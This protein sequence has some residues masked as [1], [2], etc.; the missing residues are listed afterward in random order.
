MEILGKYLSG[1]YNPSMKSREAL[2]ALAEITAYQWGM[3]TA[4]QAS[5]HGITRLDLSRLAADGQLERVAHGVYKDAGAPGGPHDALKAAWLSTD[6]K[7]MGEARLKDG[8]SGVVVA[9][10][11]AAELHAIGDFRALRHE[12]VCPGRRQ[13]QR[14]AIRYRQRTLDPSDVTLADGLPV[15]TMERTI[16]DLVDEV[17]DLSL[18]ADALRD[19]SRKRD[20]DLERLGSLL[21]PHAR[22]NGFKKGDGAALLDRLMEIAG[23]DPEAV[24]RR[25]AADASLGSRVAAT[26]LTRLSQEHIARLVM[27][28]EMQ[29]TIRSTQESV[30]ATVQSAMAPKLAAIDATVAGVSANV[31]KNSGLDEIARR[32]SAQVVNSNVMEEFSRAWV[33]ALSETIAVEPEPIT[34]NCETQNAVTRD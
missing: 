34:A 25:V 10:E 19:A 7:E 22:R 17:G 14:S 4:A 27:T 8:A 30:A 6:S 18:V 1:R 5:M 26:Y 16:A 20:L 12:F 31:V 33:K 21:A 29:Q 13:S 24:A 15:M 28:P 11:S 3:V 2:R 23:I 9:G 32:I